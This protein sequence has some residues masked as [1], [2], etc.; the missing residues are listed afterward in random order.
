[1][2]YRLNSITAS[3]FLFWSGWPEAKYGVQNI[4][5]AEMKDPWTVIGQRTLLSSPQHRWERE[6]GSNVNEAPA[7]L[8]KG[9]SIFLS[10]SASGCWTPH[11]SLG[12]LHAQLTSNLL[13]RKSWSKSSKPLLKSNSEAGVWG[14]GS[15]S[16]FSSPDG[17]EIWTAFHA[18]NDSKGDCSIKRMAHVQLVDWNAGG[19]PDLG[20]KALPRV[21]QLLAPSGDPGDADEGLNLHLG[22]PRPYLLSTSLGSYL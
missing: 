2:V 4:Y 12:L 16:W 7:P 20:E 8:I 15:N 19:N 9:D 22:V 3:W 1:M 14:C 18:V 17:S 11:Y 10:Y 6:S 21:Q 13:D 5:I